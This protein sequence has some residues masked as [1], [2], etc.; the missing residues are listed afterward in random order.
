MEN[1]SK[2]FV[3]SS[4]AAELLGYTEYYLRKLTRLNLIPAIKVSGKWR[5]D[6]DAILAANNNRCVQP[7][8]YGKTNDND[9][10]SIL[11]L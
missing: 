3:G 6:A 1:K 11:G 5:Y 9:I 2:K 7:N 8:G 10:L 4:E